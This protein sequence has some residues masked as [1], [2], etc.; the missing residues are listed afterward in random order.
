M[1][2]L[3]ST[4]YG[5]AVDPSLVNDSVPMPSE[6]S[7][8]NK[9]QYSYVNLPARMSLPKKFPDFDVIT[10]R[11]QNL[12]IRAFKDGASDPTKR[13]TPE[14]FLSALEEYI[15]GL[16]YCKCNNWDH[17]LYKDYSK[18]HCEWCRIEEVKGQKRDFDANDLFCMTNNELLHFIELLSNGEGKAVALTEYGLRCGGMALINLRGLIN[19]PVNKR[20]AKKYLKE[21][22]KMTKDSQLKDI[23]KTHLKKL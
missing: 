23:I 16:C 14:E 10:P 1:L 18:G 6:T 12:F 2:L 15:S 13:P 3:A 4:P 9:G 21:S 8:A 20:E 19:M 7:M 22:L 17:Y 5:R 11:L